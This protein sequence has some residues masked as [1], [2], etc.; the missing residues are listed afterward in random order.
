MKDQVVIITGASAGIGAELARQLGHKGAKLVLAARDESRL[1]AVAER[2]PSALAVPTDV[3]DE[4]QCYRL[5]DQAVAKFGRIDALVN[6]AGVSQWAKFEE[7]TDISLFKKL[8][9][10]NFYSVVYC[11]HAALPHLKKS[12]G[13]LVGVSSI[14]G[15][16]G[17][18]T[19][20]AYS[21]SK[22]AMQGFLDSLRIELMDTGVDILTVSPGFIQ[23]EVRE[24]ALGPDGKPVG[25]SHLTESDVMPVEECVKLIVAAMEKRQREILIGS[26][27]LR[28]VPW[29]KLLMPRTLDRWARRA[30]ETGKT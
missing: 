4:K 7:I 28:L 16:T 6:N 14:T 17:S 18:P 21:A 2:I 11:T 5:I 23:T 25:K 13:L 26:L 15:K 8:M 9:E 27:R 10:V 20:T 22:H 24:R 29:I 19:R 3:S 30:I 1:R 12:K